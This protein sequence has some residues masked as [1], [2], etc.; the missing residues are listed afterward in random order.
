[1]AAFGP[2]LLNHTS[3]MNRNIFSRSVLFLMSAGGVWSAVVNVSLFAWALHSGK[4]PTESMTL[5]FVSLVLIQFFKAYNFRSD[6]YSA[7]RRPFANKWLNR[8]I[9][10]E[11]LLLTLVIYLPFLQTPFKTVALS[12]GEQHR[13]A[14][15]AR[16][17]HDVVAVIEHLH[18]AED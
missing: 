14:I 16:P 15:R 12:L 1:M 3:R 5:V 10:W 2:L 11:L 6:F 18:G 7:F 13:F 9:L 8:A 4:S 17:N